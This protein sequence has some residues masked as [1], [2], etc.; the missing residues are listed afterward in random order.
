MISNRKVLIHVG[1]PKCASTFLQVSVLPHIPHIEFV[2]KWNNMRFLETIL[3]PEI[4][5]DPKDAAATIPAGDKP[6]VLSIEAL[7]RNPLADE[8][9]GAGLIAR[10]LKMIFPEAHI[11]FIIR[12]QIDAIES[13]MLEWI[14][15]GAFGNLGLNKFRMMANHN[16]FDLL[17]YGY[18][19]LIKFYMS[20]FESNHI[21]VLL[22]EELSRDGEKFVME[23]LSPIGITATDAS[24]S[25]RVHVRLSPFAY[26]FLRVVNLFR[27][28]RYNAAG[29][30]YS[31]RA[32]KMIHFGIAGLNRLNRYVPTFGRRVSLMSRTNRRFIRE[33]Y[34]QDN[35]ILA[36]LIGKDLET[37][38]Y[39]M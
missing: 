36:E 31:Q 6:L 16:N 10:R 18:S 38:G 23:L 11:C 17:Y 27:Y 32:T 39:P 8:P 24:R 13:M 33:Y 37:F 5:F 15:G 1:Y 21:H 9:G 4:D 19:R 14:R 26:A 25:D 35:R 34:K 3:R 2:G 29:F 28:G 20:I 30:V 12:N 7:V 22:L